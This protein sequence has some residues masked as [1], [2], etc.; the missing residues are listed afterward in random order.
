MNLKTAMTTLIVKKIYLI[1]EVVEGYYVEYNDALG[2]V[3]M[4]KF[5][6]MGELKD[7]LTDYFCCKS[8]MIKQANE[9]LNERK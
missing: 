9:V 5:R 1:K 2:E 6:G 4:K 3:G 7:F 8:E